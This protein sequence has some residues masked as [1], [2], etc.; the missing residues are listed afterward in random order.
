MEELGE[1]TAGFYHGSIDALAVGS[2][3][4]ADVL[5]GLDSE[6]FSGQETIIYRPDAASAA[7][8]VRRAGSLT[9]ATG[10]LAHTGTN[11][12][13]TT[14]TSETIEF[15]H[16]GV[17]PDKDVHPAI[18][19]A[20]EFIDFDTFMGI[21]HMGDLDGDM[22]V[23][24]DTNWSDVGTPTTSAK[25]VVA[26]R[27][28]YG[29]R[30]Y[31]LIND[32]ANEGTQSATLP[33]TQGDL[34]RAF[35]IAS[36]NVGTASFRFYDVTNSTEFDGAAVTHSEEEPQLMVQPWQRA[37]DDCKEMA[38]RMLGTT[39]TSD[40]FWNQL[41]VYKQGVLRINLPNYINERFK[42]P[43]IFEARPTVN[44]AANVWNAAS[45]TFVPLQEGLDY[46]YITAQNDA[47]PHAIQMREG[48]AY[49]WP[50]F[51]MARLPYSAMGALT[52]EADTTNAPLHLITPRVRLELL[53]SV[54]QFKIPEAQ[55]RR[56]VAQALND[57]DNSTQART[58][59]QPGRSKPWFRGP[60]RI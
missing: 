58:P 43:R 5:R 13:D 49:E 51:V 30:S 53:N 50:L 52:A 48:W 18:N 11:Y 2:V 59:T 29:V 9:S 23:S 27:T 47:N 33:V 46:H 10:L 19:R 38:L 24:T 15:W 1:R 54:Y 25:S 17:R 40:V 45:V 39:T 26:R 60:M 22:F 44:T 57:R 7:D 32:A 42:Q 20:L 35:T 16:H 14:A 3:T 56:L 28:P 8:T 4:V 34:V 36:V 37:P 55:Y 31:N 6:S 41:W 21:S 12:S